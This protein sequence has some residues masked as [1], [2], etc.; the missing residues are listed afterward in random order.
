MSIK[1]LAKNILNK[2]QTY[3][4]HKEQNEEAKRI[5]KIVETEGNRLDPYI[6]NICNE[7]SLD[8]FGD[9][10]YA[11]WLYVYS[12]YA[13]EF[14][15]GWIPDNFYG[16][17]VVPNLKGEYGKLCDRNA[18]INKILKRTD[19]LDIGYY[20]NRLFLNAQHEIMH[21]TKLKDILFAKNDKIV[22]KIENSLQGKGV[23]FFNEKS[24]DINTIK[25]LGNGVFQEYIEQHP[26]FAEFHKT[27]VA[28]IRLTSTCDDY[29]NINVKAGYLRFG[30]GNDTHVI[31][32]RQMRIP[33]EIN[34]GKLFG[35]AFFPKSQSTQHLPGNTMEF[36]GRSLPAFEDCL[37]V[38]KR[39]HNHI[40]F[41]RCIG[42][43]I[44]LD[45]Y[46]K[47]K[48]IELNGGHNG[49][50]FNEMV[51]GPCFKGL[52]WEKLIK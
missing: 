44:I 2:G 23:Y 21:E 6:R 46:N 3:I 16:E 38:V 43:D 20:V 18:I 13:R 42:W 26:F 27:S 33:I 52:G 14:K 24:F 17:Y 22:Y 7:Y 39:L 4:Y 37:T 10:K 48:I 51:Q 8:V 28:T 25:K 47:V 34:T 11:P 32:N 1:K 50:S 30:R 15:E 49:I 19:S 12:A 41:I 35:T 36:S 31:S 9:K 40:P 45:K 29:G 5:L